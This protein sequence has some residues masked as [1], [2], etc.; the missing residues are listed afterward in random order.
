MIKKRVLYIVNPHSGVGKK[1]A[2]EMEILQRTDPDFVEYDIIHTE[3]GGHATELT[4]KYRDKVDVIVAVGGDGTVNEVGSGLINH[5]TAMGIIPCGSGNGLARELDIPLRSSL[6]ID[7]I[8]ETF[9]RRIDVMKINDS[10]SLNVSGIGFD[11]Y[12]SHK[13]AKVK[14][15]G[16]LKYMN[17]IAREFPKYEPQE[18]VLTIDG[19]IFKRKAFLVSFAN[20][21]QWGNNV[22]I[23]PTAQMDDGLIDVCIVSEFPNLAIPSLLFSLF[24]Q[25]IEKNKYDEI[26]QARNIE[27]CSN[28]PLYGHADGEPI[29]IAPNTTISVMPLALNV[30]VP[31]QEFFKTSRF[32]PT[33][34][35][36]AIID[37]IHSTLK[38]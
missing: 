3:Y 17:L 29:M 4:L 32:N 34:I 35:S 11:A 33:T 30:V 9:T 27:I 21:S 8:N 31:S 37:K 10:Y 2:I 12:I 13:F 16:P 28:E 19:H 36:G 25:S 38:H 22:H 14:T 6:A 15:R 18:Y 5:K 1:R 20:S 24:N 7:V 23:A 26:I